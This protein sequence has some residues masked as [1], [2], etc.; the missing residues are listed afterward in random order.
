[1]LRPYRVLDLTNNGGL[2]CGQILADLGADVIVVEPPGGSPA[3][4]IGPFRTRNAERGMRNG[5]AGSNSA[6]EE[7]LF[8]WAY[9]RNKRSVTLDLES[10]DGRESF[11]RLVPTADF[12]IES[13]AP[14]YLDG[15]GIG[16]AALSEINPRLVMVSITPFGQQGPKAGWAATELTAL[17]SSGVLLIT[18]DEDRPPVRL[19]GEQAFLHAGAEAAVGALIAQAGRE[20]DGVGQHVDVSV[21][22]AAMMATQ[23]AILQWGWDRASVISRVAGGV[24]LG[25][26][27][28]RFVYA[29]ADGHVSVTFLFGTV[30]GPFTRRLF[31]WMYEE[32]FVDEATRDKDWV[33]YVVLLLTGQEPASELDRCTAAIERFTR[34]KTKAELFAEAM[35]RGL[36]IVPVSTTADVA[37][38]EQLAARAYWIEVEH[39]ELAGGADPPGRPSITYPGPFAK[40]SATPIQYHRRPPLVG[41]H[42]DEVLREPGAGRRVPAASPGTSAARSQSAT[43]TARRPAPGTRLPLA[44]VKVL[45]FSWVFA[46][47]MGVRYLS[48]YGATVIHVESATRPDAL[49][50]YAPFKDGQP[51][52]ERSGQYINVQAGKLGLSLN[53]ATAAGREV[54]LRLVQWADVVVE[55]YSPRAM[56]KWG[57]HYE[58]L[59]E[60][61][62]GIIMLSSSLN[63]QTGPQSSLAGF[64]TMGAQLAGFGALV[65]WPD[66]PPAGPYVAYT[67][68]I[69]PKLVAAALLAALDHRRRTGAGQYIDFSQAEGS[70]HF[71]APQ[72]LDYFVNGRVETRNG[73]FS[74]EHTP[75][76]VYPCL[77]DDRWVA[78]ACGTEE[79]W[80]GVCAAAGHPE[81]QTDPRFATFAARQANHEALDAAI[82]AWTATRDVDAVEQTLQA[83]GVP[84]HRATSSADAFADPQLQFR[85]HFVAVE[86]PEIGSVPIESS[87]MRFSHTPAQVSTP[88][89]TFGEHNDRVLREVLGMSDEEVVELLVSGALE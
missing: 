5:E 35:R 12:V 13:F 29:C 59:R 73:N 81:W 40:F 75:H 52:P 38:S 28:L 30:I 1:M 69:S 63:G 71:L 77:G 26:I 67:D 68:Y 18:G 27:R 87:R 45:D 55:S 60:V 10:E 33:N 70:I 20:R 88:G 83:A 8:W 15:L 46:T 86:H 39:P 53:L 9:N 82:G 74:A 23:S 76:G 21:Q 19:P 57:M 24:K 49:R 7:S 3:R 4:R 56:R 61:N 37:G 84:V 2:L 64:G 85:G 43:E 78:I 44:G 48:D 79:Q 41:E 25:P 54:A 42:T 62:P 32:G 47:P 80:R 66:R 36:L 31:D 14:G 50:T 58:A 6:L 89:P 34:T 17:A 16:Y 51:G 65:G 11:R 22:T 72:M